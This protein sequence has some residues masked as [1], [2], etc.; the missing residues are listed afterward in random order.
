MSGRRGSQRRKN[1]RTAKA[2]DGIRTAAGLDLSSLPKPALV[3]AGRK[4]REF[5]YRQKYANMNHFL[6]TGEIRE[7]FP[8]ECLTQ[9]G[10]TVESV[11]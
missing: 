2:G 4:L 1:A 11:S 3:E 7:P 10:V 9:L 8:H 6:Q 5:L